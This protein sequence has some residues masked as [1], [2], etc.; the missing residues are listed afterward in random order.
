[1]ADSSDVKAAAAAA[2]GG[3]KGK[4]YAVEHLEEGVP[5]WCALEY[6]H[7]CEVV[8]DER[9]AFTKWPNEDRS[10]ACVDS[11]FAPRVYTESI[12][13]LQK[14]FPRER[15]VLMDMDASEPLT[16][17]DAALFDTVLFGGI[18]G[19]VP[20][21]DRTQE[22]RKVGFPHRRNLGSV[23]MT[24]DTAMLVCKIVLEDG[25]ALEKIPYV[26]H[27]DIRTGAHDST[28]MPFRYVALSHR[29]KK[30]AD[31]NTPILPRGMVE[32]LRESA[33]DDLMDEL[34]Q[35]PSHP[36]LTQSMPADGV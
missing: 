35:E 17:A 6:G 22:L 2:A 10:F 11:R 9:L 14:D 20:S 18:L 13:D 5:R 4:I 21:D 26:D 31:A 7:M 16:P 30:A 36:L 29:S 23:Q 33:D 25:V 19:N 32:L 1:M 15:T 8:K 34:L 27:P 24:T 12:A 3:G 28:N